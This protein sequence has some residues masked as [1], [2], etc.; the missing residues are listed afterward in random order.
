MG[1][2]IDGGSSSDEDDAH[3]KAK[4]DSIASTTTFGTKVLG[5]V[6]DTPSSNR[7]VDDQ[8][9]KPKHCQLKAQMLL[10]NILKK[11]VK[12]VSKPI[13]EPNNHLGDEGGVRLFKN[14]PAGIA[15]DYRDKIEGPKKRPR[16]L[17]RYDIDEKSKKFRRKIKAIA[18]NGVDIIA[19]AREAG[20]KTRARLEIKE[21]ARKAKAKAEEERIAEL[22][23]IRG[24]RWLPAIAKEMQLSRNAKKRM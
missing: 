18:V 10:D 13:P 11:T 16:L 23:R 15:F 5:S 24:E 6:S 9:Q 12:I 8:T 3:F 22:K 7:D 1:V 17:P 14:S 20:K 2:P 21:E 4:I 19:D